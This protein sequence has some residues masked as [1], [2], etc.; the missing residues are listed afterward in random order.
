MQ[1]CTQN[2][3]C[4][5]FGWLL[6]TY[7]DTYNSIPL[8]LILYAE[9]ARLPT[10]SYSNSYSSSYFALRCSAHT[11]SILRRWF[12]NKKAFLRVVVVCHTDFSET[13]CQIIYNRAVS[14]M[15]MIMLTRIYFLLCCWPMSVCVLLGTTGS[16]RYF[17]KYV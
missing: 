10:H 12:R 15:M 4:R 5:C 3:P 8:L 11:L 2:K 1:F 13:D 14:M 9:H 6:R 7:S 17:T 16:I